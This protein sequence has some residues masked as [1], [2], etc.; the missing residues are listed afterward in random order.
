MIEQGYTEITIKRTFLGRSRILANKDGHLREL[1]VDRLG[2][3]LSDIS[4]TQ[5]GEILH[6]LHIGEGGEEVETQTIGE[7][8]LES[9]FD[10]E[11]D[12]KLNENNPGED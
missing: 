3:I 4:S 7:G 11:D 1:I 10:D 9:E 6:K 5:E 8:G 12:D 2:R